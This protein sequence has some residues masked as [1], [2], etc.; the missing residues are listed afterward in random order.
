MLLWS[1]DMHIYFFFK[2]CIFTFVYSSLYRRRLYDLVYI[3]QCGCKCTVPVKVEKQ[4]KRRLGTR[5]NS[6][7]TPWKFSTP[8]TVSELLESQLS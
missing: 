7:Q 6:D 3:I 1:I 4:E 2:I 5:E 8:R